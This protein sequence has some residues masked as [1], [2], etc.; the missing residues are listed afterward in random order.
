MKLKIQDL[1]ENSPKSWNHSNIENNTSDRFNG[2][3]NK[4]MG[5]IIHLIHNTVNS[6]DQQ[7]DYESPL[8]CEIQEAISIP[9]FK[10]NFQNIHI[11]FINI[12]RPVLNVDINT[13]HKLL[14]KAVAENNPKIL[15][16]ESIFG[17][18]IIELPKKIDIEVNKN[19]QQIGSTYSNPSL[20]PTKVPIFAL[21]ISK[22]IQSLKAQEL[23]EI[24]NMEFIEI[25]KVNQMILNGEILDAM[26]ITAIKQL[27]LHL[28]FQK[29]QDQKPKKISS[30]MEFLFNLNPFS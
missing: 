3:I 21:D 6:A 25:N 8:F 18:T 28:D 15:S 11:G 22:S 1:N 24:S 23:N 29:N 2:I 4:K 27:E 13:Y 12:E 10:D 16:Q 26:S 7:F 17:D 20:I 9:Y 14:E 5:M 30:Y 19:I